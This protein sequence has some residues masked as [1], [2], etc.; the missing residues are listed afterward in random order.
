MRAA[1]PQVTRSGQSAH[2]PNPGREAEL[3]PLADAQAIVRRARRFV[4]RLIEPATNM[5]TVVVHVARRDG[6]RQGRHQLA[7]SLREAEL[8][9]TAERLER[10]LGSESTGAALETWAPR[11]VVEAALRA[12]L[13]GV[14]LRRTLPLSGSQ[15]LH[16]GA[17]S[18]SLLLCCDVLCHFGR[19][20][21]QSLS[22]ATGFML[23]VHAFPIATSSCLGRGR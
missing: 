1:G 4:P 2:S 8:V 3:D 13:R 11:S 21:T 6:R 14:V 19:G 9:D 16:L 5:C 12:A 7:A 18:G 15:R 23:T 22:R 10:A 20:L 17:E